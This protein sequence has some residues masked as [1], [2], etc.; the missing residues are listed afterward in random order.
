[1]I[2]KSKK[3]LLPLIMVLILYS[4]LSG[5]YHNYKMCQM[6][7]ELEQE[8]TVAA[9]KELARKDSLLNVYPEESDR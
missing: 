6:R 3:Y 1:M 5:C 4:K 2:D 8:I 7:C 9:E